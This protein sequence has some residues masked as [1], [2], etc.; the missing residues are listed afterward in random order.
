MLGA[1]TGVLFLVIVGGLTWFTISAL[2]Y[3]A[4]K[5]GKTTYASVVSPAA[6]MLAL[7]MICSP[8]ACIYACRSTSICYD[9]PVKHRIGQAAAVTLP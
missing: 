6:I 1:V 5:T 9:R 7:A 4:E 2:I 8:A 3:A